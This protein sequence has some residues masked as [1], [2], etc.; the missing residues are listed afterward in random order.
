MVNPEKICEY[1][2]RLLKLCGKF[3]FIADEILSTPD[4]AAKEELYREARKILREMD[5][6]ASHIN[7]LVEY[8]SV[9]VCFPPIRLN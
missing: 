7:D 8:T 6:M 4:G 1:N 2:N 3:M 9:K 5:C